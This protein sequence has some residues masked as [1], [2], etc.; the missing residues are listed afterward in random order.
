MVWGGGGGSDQRWTRVIATRRAVDCLVIY[1]IPSGYP[2]RP[3]PPSHSLYT[4]SCVYQPHPP[5]RH[6]VSS[7][8]SPPP[9]PPLRLYIRNL[10]ILTPRTPPHPI[11][12]WH[13]PRP[14]TN[15][16]NHIKPGR[17][18]LGTF[19]NS[20]LRIQCK[21][22][23]KACMPRAGSARLE[24]TGGRF[25]VTGVVVADNGLRISQRRDLLVY[26]QRQCFTLSQWVVLESQ[27]YAFFQFQFGI[28]PFPQLE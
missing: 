4:P 6:H 24:E 3:T 23:L 2:A 15:T 13:V 1:R 18:G 10:V 28:D 25:K 20:W 8:W 11:A 14:A 5:P 16:Y 26:R 7:P 9:P 12:Q 27:K 19:S 17:Q 21:Y 22:G